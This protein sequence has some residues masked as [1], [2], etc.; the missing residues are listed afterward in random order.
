M[1]CVFFELLKLTEQPGFLVRPLS[2]PP[3]HDSVFQSSFEAFEEAFVDLL[4]DVGL[5]GHLGWLR[6][7]ESA[8]PMY[9]ET[10]RGRTLRPSA[11]CCCSPPFPARSTNC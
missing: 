4:L 3:G 8:Q 9:N 10:L 7:I 11:I 2:F 6:V 5:A 1:A